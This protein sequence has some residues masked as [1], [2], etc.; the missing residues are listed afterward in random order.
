MSGPTLFNEDGEP[1]FTP[2]RPGIVVL[3]DLLEYIQEMRNLYTD[4]QELYEVLQ[5][6][7]SF[8]GSGSPKGVYANLAALQA[9]KPTGDSFIYLTT[10]NGNW[11]YWNGTTWTSGG[12]Y[13][14]S[15]GI[16]TDD[17]FYKAMNGEHT[18]KTTTTSYKNKISNNIT[19]NGNKAFRDGGMTLKRPEQFAVEFDQ[20]RYNNIMDLNNVNVLQGSNTSGQMGLFNFGFD[21]IKKI[22]DEYGEGIYQVTSLIDKIKVTPN[23][24]QSLTF[25]FYGFGTHPDGNGCAIAC[26]NYTTATWDTISTDNSNTPQKLEITVSDL[27]NRIHPTNGYVYFIAYPSK[28][29][30]GITPSSINVDYCDLKINL[31]FSFD[32]RYYTQSQT[33]AIMNQIPSM[34]DYSN[35]IIVSGLRVYDSNTL[36][37]SIQDGIAY[38]NK[39]RIEKA[40]YNVTYQPNKDTYIDLD[41]NGQYL[42]TV[43]DN[44]SPSP[45]ITQNSI[46]IGSVV[47]NDNDV[48]ANRSYNSNFAMGY[49]T[50]SKKGLHQHNTAIGFQALK[51]NQADGVVYDNGLYNTAVG[52]WALKENTTG[53]H[54]TGIGFEAL[55]NNTTGLQNTGI[56]EAS[57]F[58]N[59]TGNHN[60]ALGVHVMMQNTIGNYNVA[61]GNYALELNKTGNYNTA[62]GYGAGKNP[63][64]YKNAIAI[65][66]NSPIE[67]DDSIQLGNESVNKARLYGSYES[68]KQGSGFISKSPDGSR[69]I[70]NVL[71]DGSLKTTKL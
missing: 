57:L 1:L 51:N 28:L 49:E 23:I 45:P 32:K 31:D 26:Y 41:D 60:T 50:L 10:D 34:L 43:V 18:I 17:Q 22:T 61:I 58:F 71:D 40:G 20:T 67:E 8:I 66:Y 68:L 63:N 36:Q 5:Q 69:W 13:Q 16:L 46:R 53:N 25:E 3:G 15:N 55:M 33:N 70:I 19:T 35:N 2:E 38:V 39:K 11:Y 64:N 7:L 6:N 52:S 54:N 62:V 30:D 65:G 29:S 27:K 24:V 37:S 12:V 44:G 9:A 59:T 56:G 21:V 42:F 48:I 47:T 14:A 4:T